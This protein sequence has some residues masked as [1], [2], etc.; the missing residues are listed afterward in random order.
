[1]AAQGDSAQTTGKEHERAD[2]PRGARWW[3]AA[4][5][6]A[7][8][9]YVKNPFA[10]VGVTSKSTISSGISSALESR[11]KLI[12][13]NWW[14][15]PDTESSSVHPSYTCT[16]VCLLPFQQKN[17]RPKVHGSIWG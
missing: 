17:E 13:S 2:I 12:C 10:A 6:F 9:A 15:K 7:M 8:A 3:N 11:G 1:M 14:Q 16:I 5:E 4:K